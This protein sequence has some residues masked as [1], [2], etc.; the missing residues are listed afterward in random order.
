MHSYQV[1]SLTPQTKKGAEK[2]VYCLK[3]ICAEDYA[4]GDWLMVQPENP[5]DIVNDVLEALSLNGR[6]MLRLRRL[7]EM[8]A[9]R[10]LKHHLEIT[11]LDPAALYRLQREEGIG[12]WP[13]RQAIVAYA[14]GKNLLDYLNDFPAAQAL[15]R[16]LLDRLSPLAPRFYSIASSPSA[17]AG[18]LHV[19]FRVM[20][21]SVRGKC[22]EGAATSMMARLAP[23][24]VLQG[25]IQANPHF[26]LPENEAAPVIMIASGVGLAP[27][28]GFI[29]HRVAQQAKGENWLFFGETSRHRTFLC[30]QQLEH[31][32][33][34][35]VLKLTTAF[36]RDQA[37]KVY[38]QH[39]LQEAAQT[40]RESVDEG[41]YLYLCGDKHKMAP[42]VLEVLQDL[43]GT[44]RFEALKAEKRL[45]LDVF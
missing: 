25:K 24:D 26:K 12:G 4:P 20:T 43:L 36:S 9:Y 14:Q 15:G 16:R 37:E 39:R 5:D 22:Y 34:Q 23:G 28:M 40:L 8:S 13:D 6:A 45:Q 38:V 7:G 33:A 31:W 18:E 35:G 21:H 29:A 32:Q 10:A 44:A 1:I 2:T 27:F 17:T 19:L 30:Q 11:L 3:L 42:A 41:A